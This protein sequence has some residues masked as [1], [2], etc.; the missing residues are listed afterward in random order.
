ML[1]SLCTTVDRLSTRLESEVHQINSSAEGAE[2]GGGGATLKLPPVSPTPGDG[3]RSAMSVLDH[4]AL[5]HLV[6]RIEHLSAG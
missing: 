2:G 3:R 4:G 1:S 5:D 6:S